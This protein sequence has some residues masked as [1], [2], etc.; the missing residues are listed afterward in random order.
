MSLLF[1]MSSG[2]PTLSTF[3]Q[4]HFGI[5]YVVQLMRSLLHLES[6][7]PNSSGWMLDPGLLGRDEPWSIPIGRVLH[8]RRS[9]CIFYVP[10][11]TV[12]IWLI[13][14]WFV[15]CHSFLRLHL[16]TIH[17]FYNYF[18]MGSPMPQFRPLWPR[19]PMP[20]NVKIAQQIRGE[21]ASKVAKTRAPIA[22]KK[23]QRYRKK[24]CLSLV[25]VDYFALSHI[26]FS[27]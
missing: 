8:P 25:Y 1:R 26:G 16:L 17:S 20:N 5:V 19:L 24:V 4:V 9:P 3:Q 13:K 12:H 22:C 27:H 18:L 15:R 6:N 14:G 2:L 10:L 7:P 11:L 23:C 21:T